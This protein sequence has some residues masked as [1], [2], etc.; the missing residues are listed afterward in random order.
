MPLDEC[1]GASFDLLFLVPLI[2]IVL[3]LIA[4]T[5][6]VY[7]LHNRAILTS[8][9]LILHEHDQYYQVL[10]ETRHSNRATYRYDAEENLGPVFFPNRNVSYDVEARG[11]QMG[12]DDNGDSHLPEE[13]HTELD[14]G[15][16]DFLVGTVS[17]ARGSTRAVVQVQFTPMAFW[18]ETY[19]T[20]ADTVYLAAADWRYDELPGGYTGWLRRQLDFNRIRDYIFD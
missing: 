15:A 9:C 1:G 17:N 14:R 20:L 12:I 7:Y 5:G 16:W 4:L 6:E 2:V 19:G 10:A 3:A 11:R 18:P 8:K 13:S